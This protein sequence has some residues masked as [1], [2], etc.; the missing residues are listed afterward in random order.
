MLPVALEAFVM[1]FALSPA[2]C[3]TLALL[4]FAG[5]PGEPEPGAEEKVPAALPEIASKRPEKVREVKID[6][7]EK[8]PVCRRYVPTGSRIATER[9]ETPEPKSATAAQRANHDVLRREVE[10]MRSLQSMREQARSQ[11]IAEAL[12]RRGGGL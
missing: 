12:R 4:P 5:S 6:P 11:A 9:C 3:L 7:N 10:E 8:L 1:R 2:A